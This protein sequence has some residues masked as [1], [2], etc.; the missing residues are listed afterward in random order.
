MEVQQ[1]KVGRERERDVVHSKQIELIKYHVIARPGAFLMLVFNCR[2]LFTGL[3]NSL[4]PSGYHSDYDSFC[5]R[6]G[7][8][9]ISV[10]GS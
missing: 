8:M 7:V 1:D 5:Q 4:L 10:R 2:S 9:D 3:R 6:R